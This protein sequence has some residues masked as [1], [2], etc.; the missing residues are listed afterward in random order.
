MK[1]IY[2][3][4]EE[5]NDLDLVKYDI[6]DLINTK[7]FGNYTTNILEQNNKKID[8]ITKKRLI[9]FMKDISKNISPNITII[10]LREKHFPEIYKKEE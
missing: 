4:F 7:T 8:K 9:N 6:I 5:D 10:E 2:I 1:E 3:K